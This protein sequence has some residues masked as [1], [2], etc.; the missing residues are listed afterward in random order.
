MREY[1]ECISA[2]DDLEGLEVPIPVLDAELSAIDAEYVDIQRSVAALEK[3]L[4]E[5]KASCESQ[6]LTVSTLGAITIL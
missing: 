2:V 4:I 1:E 3:R 6:L 5:I